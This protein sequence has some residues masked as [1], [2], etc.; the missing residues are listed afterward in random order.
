MR[1]RDIKTCTVT[2]I[3]K[4]IYTRR[5]LLLPAYPSARHAEKY[6]CPATKYYY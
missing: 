3:Q 1:P 4:P 5:L 2:V 6:R